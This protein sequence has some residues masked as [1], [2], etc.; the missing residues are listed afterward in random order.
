MVPQVVPVTLHVTAVLVAFATVA[1]KVIAPPAVTEGVRGEIVTVTGGGGA[2]TVTAA[3]P[4]AVE[5]ATLVAR[6]VYDPAVAGAVYRPVESTVP[7]LA[8][9]TVQVTAVLAVPVTAAARR[10]VAFGATVAVVGTTWTS[11][12]WAAVL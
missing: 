12:P 6:T 8:C 11:T 4:C 1:V 5:S 7:P 9:T 10:V 2:V 3:S